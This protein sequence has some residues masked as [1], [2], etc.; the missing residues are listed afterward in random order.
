MD[1]MEPFD[2]EKAARVWQRVRQDPSPAPAETELL[3]LIAQERAD[4][5]TYLQLSRRFQGK[6]SAALRQMAQQE[7]AHSACLKG[8]YTLLTGAPPVL[9][10]PTPPPEDTASALRRCYGAEMRSL[11]AYEK[12]TNDPQYGPVFTRLAQQEQ[13]HCHTLLE[14]IGKVSGK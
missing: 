11:A 7:Q 12:R 4:A 1:V 14:L 9:E 5:A 6:E 2:Q 3:G 10:R 8:I 13:S